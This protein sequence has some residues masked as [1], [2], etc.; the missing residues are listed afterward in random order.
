[1]LGIVRRDI[2]REMN[3]GRQAARD[4]L[5]GAKDDPKKVSEIWAEFQ[6]C[7]VG[8][9]YDRGYRAELTDYNKR[10]KAAKK[11]VRA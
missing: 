7:S 1:M 10:N 5:A 9:D 3:R 4:A 2:D 6:R 11:P 8:D